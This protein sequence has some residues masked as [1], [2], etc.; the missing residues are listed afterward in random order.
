MRRNSVNIMRILMERKG[1]NVPAIGVYKM[2]IL[3][4]SV[5]SLSV[6]PFGLV[7]S[8]RKCVF[9][10]ILKLT[11]PLRPSEALIMCLLIKSS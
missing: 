9:T 8:F 7:L 4:N 2:T 1:Y 5:Y 11:R 6:R 10:L 3:I